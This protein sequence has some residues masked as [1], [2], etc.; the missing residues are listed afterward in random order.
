[1]QFI[2]KQLANSFFY[3]GDICSK[4]ITND[5]TWYLYQKSMFLSL[6]FDDKIIDEKAKVWQ[7]PKKVVRK[8]VGPVKKPTKRKLTK[9]TIKRNIN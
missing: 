3:I 7:K 4:Y 1:M 2:Y 5:I 6:Y 9:R 8:K